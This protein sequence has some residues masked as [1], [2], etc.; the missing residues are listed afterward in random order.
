MTRLS[1]NISAILNDFINKLISLEDALAKILRLIES[2][3]GASLAAQRKRVDKACAKCGRMMLNV[4]EIKDLCN[5]CRKT[6]NTRTY[7]ERL[8]NKGS[9]G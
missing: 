9:D 4:Y 3:S 6:Q 5:T 8:K 2:E 1:A 7:R